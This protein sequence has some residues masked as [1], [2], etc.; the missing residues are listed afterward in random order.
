MKGRHSGEG[1]HDYDSADAY[2]HENANDPN[3]CS[4]PGKRTCLRRWEDR[5][6][7]L[8]DWIPVVSYYEDG[9]IVL[10]AGDRRD[11]T[12]QDRLNSYTPESV[13]V[14]EREEAWQ[15]EPWCVES[16][17]GTFHFRDGFT[18]PAPTKAFK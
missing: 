6:V 16:G 15:G 13:N 8:Y 14:V 18:L 3:A 5:I 7:V 9:A 11:D 1:V 12:M 17:H 2:I 4:L 10:E